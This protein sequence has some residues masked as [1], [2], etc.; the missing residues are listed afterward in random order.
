MWG[1]GSQTGPVVQ[2][3]TGL[4]AGVA[5]VG[6]GPV[7]QSAVGVAGQTLPLLFVWEEALGTVE[8]ADALM[9]EA[10]L[11]AACTERTAFQHRRLGGRFSATQGNY[12]K[13]PQSL[14]RG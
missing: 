1:A 6:V 12:A 5:V 10:I 3:G 8:H 7:A 13:Y 11:L 9:E 14:R 2:S 4:Q